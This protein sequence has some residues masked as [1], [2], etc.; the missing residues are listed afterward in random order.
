[1]KFYEEEPSFFQKHRLILAGI[2]VT[3]IAGAVWSAQK[4]FQRT[5]QSR[6]EQR[7]VMVSLPPTSHL[8]PP[9]VQA[10]PPPTELEQK[11]IMQDPVNAM[12]FK[13]DE[14]PSVA[15]AADETPGVGTSIQGDGP[16]DAFGLRGRNS[17][18]NFV[19][20]AKTEQR[21]T[22][23]RWGWYAGQVQQAISRAL[24]DHKSTR[25][26]DFRVE[27]KIWA[28]Q[29]GRITRARLDGSTGNVALD[30]AI[31]DDVLTGLVLQESPP[32]GMPM[33]IV[34]RLTARRAPGSNTKQLAA[35]Q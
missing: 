26:A 24:Q 25:T 33:P 3:V 18:G 35:N 28:D 29:A 31:A 30:K 15:P 16:A 23:T 17:F 7:M 10:P 9:P 20:S 8:P 5:S 22:G 34:L 21:T 14:T 19:G 32:D 13:S 12:E 1:M 6:P 27:A 11:M 4:L 2:I